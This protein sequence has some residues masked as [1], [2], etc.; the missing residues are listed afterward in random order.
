[1]KSHALRSVARLAGALSAAAVA[2]WCLA[3][4]A[5]GNAGAAAATPA[6]HHTATA[7][8]DSAPASRATDLSA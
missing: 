5:A 2:V 3:G 1:M 8:A 6:R 4:V 7:A